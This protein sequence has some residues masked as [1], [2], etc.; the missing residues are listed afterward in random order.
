[1]FIN[2]SAINLKVSKLLAMKISDKVDIQNDNI[3]TKH[4][5]II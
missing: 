5:I 3:M 4:H 1:M 2:I